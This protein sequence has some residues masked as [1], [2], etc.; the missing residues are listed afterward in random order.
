MP[1]YFFD[2]HDGI[3]VLDNHG[4]YLK[5]ICEAK[6]D[7]MRIAS[8]YATKPEMIGLSGGAI[9]INIRSADGSEVATVRLIFTIDDNPLQ[10]LP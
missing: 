7:A 1:R 8:I 6:S 9:V 3:S 5:D 10:I 4:R 2:I